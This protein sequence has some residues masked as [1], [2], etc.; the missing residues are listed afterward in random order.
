MEP[1]IRTLRLLGPLAL[2][3]I[4]VAGAHPG[5]AGAQAPQPP[6]PS[7]AANNVTSSLTGT[8][9]DSDGGTIAGAQVTL[10]FGPQPT[11]DSATVRTGDDGR[12]T[13]PNLPPG[14]FRLSVNA[15]G[16]SP[17]QISGEFQPSESRDLGPIALHAGSSTDIQVSASKGEVAEAEIRQEEKQ[18]VLGIIPNYFVVYESNPTPLGSRQKFELAWKTQID[19]VSFAL[20]GVIAGA[21]QATHTYA[22]EQGA[23]GYAK[24]YAASYGTFLTGN[25]LSDAV[26][27]TIFKQDPRYFYKGTGS[28]RSRIF[29]AIANAVICKG[30]NQHWQLN[31]SG[32][33][34]GLAAS[35][36]SNLYYPKADRNGAALT[37]EGAAIGTGFV[38][39]GNLMQEFVVRKLTP[40]AP[41]R[42]TAKP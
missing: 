33:L 27:P 34:G 21:E 23:S 15:E 37:F 7:S 29:Y 30:D 14:P 28:V 16:F 25:F 9:T 6:P 20:T 31:Y 8:V 40:H 41:H 17:Q 22:W 24:R 13:F 4:L 18:R 11:P 2:S 1:V 38:A 12:F 5:A 3:V 42:S 19:P 26:F 36:I 39:V 35:G 32:I 10:T